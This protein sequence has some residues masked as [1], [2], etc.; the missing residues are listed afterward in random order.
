MSL[1]KAVETIRKNKSFLITAHTNPEGDALGSELA[2]YLLLRKL[3]KE[4]VIVNEDSA[5]YGYEFLPGIDN[6]R[7]YKSESQKFNFDCF[8]TL[9]SSDLKRT[10]EVYRLNCNNK[11]VFNIDH[12]IS[13]TK[14]GNVNWVEPG[15]S[16]C[17]EMIYRLY[18]AMKVGIDKDAA[19]ALYTGILTDTGSFR[20]SNTSSFTHHAVAELL[21]YGID[22]PEVYK[23]AYENIPF[24]DMKLLI[25][26]LPEIKR[27]VKGKLIW[28]QVPH[29]L[30]KRNKVSF[31]LAEHLLTFGR[32]IKGVDVVALFKENLGVKDEI[33]VNLRSQSRVDVNEIASYFGGGGHKAAA[34]IT[35]RGKIDEIRRKVLAKI[36]E[37]L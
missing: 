12:H 19:L 2:F 35:I 34:G 10:G 27:C 31:D 33:R 24:E 8:V 20:Y 37:A 13:N 30:L 22:V 25:K 36:K 1:K 23:C 32:E 18:K 7:R 16:S 11:P 3:G 14:F 17:S 9:D 28:F 4:A 29:N 26:I 5:L 6:I 21:K 15:A